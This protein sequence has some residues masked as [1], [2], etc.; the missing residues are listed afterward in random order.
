MAN[1]WARPGEVVTTDSINH[2]CSGPPLQRRGCAYTARAAA[3]EAEGSRWAS[4]AATSRFGLTVPEPKIRPINT[5]E[6][7]AA[8]RRQA[9][10]RSI[11]S[12]STAG[13]P[14]MSDGHGRPHGGHK[15]SVAGRKSGVRPAASRGANNLVGPC[16]GMTER[17]LHG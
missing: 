11:R 2:K 3:V 15:V 10:W 1:V 12:Q 9:G 17:S 13:K 5:A 4:T 7:I 6:P 16:W 8:Q 14:H